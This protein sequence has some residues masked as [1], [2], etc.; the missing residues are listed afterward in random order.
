MKKLI[1]HIF[2][3]KSRIAI[4]GLYFS[5]MSSSFILLYWI[6]EWSDLLDLTEAEIRYKGLALII[7]TTLI[8]HILIVNGK[9]IAA[10][11]IDRKK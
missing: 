11:W 1:Q 6:S 10:N 5:A 8:R 3:N 9:D 4:L 7:G 2:P